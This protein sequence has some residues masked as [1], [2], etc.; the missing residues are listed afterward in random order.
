MTIHNS[1]VDKAQL[2]WWLMGEK[3]EK[4]KLELII[5]IQIGS[6]SLKHLNFKRKTGVQSQ[7]STCEMQTK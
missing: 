3:I 1:I 6:A 2:S 4:Q 7:G 5:Q